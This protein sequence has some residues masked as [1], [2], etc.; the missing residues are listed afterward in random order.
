MLEYKATSRENN[1]VPREGS[2]NMRNKQFLEPGVLSSWAVIA[3]GDQRYKPNQMD[4]EN[5]VVELS[6]NCASAGMVIQEKRPPILMF[7]GD[8]SVEQMMFEAYNAAG[9]HSK[10]VHPFIKHR[11]RN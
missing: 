7:A 5:F 9:E 10:L 8:T 1:F 6:K 11:C 3:I 4:I 2:W